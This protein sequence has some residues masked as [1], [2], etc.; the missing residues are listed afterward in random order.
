M[1]KVDK[2]YEV[3]L[4]HPKYKD[5]VLELKF[6]DEEA[7]QRWLPVIIKIEAI[8]LSMSYKQLRDSSTG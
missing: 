2:Q 3:R 8:I 5:D 7:F 4:N 6:R 1:L